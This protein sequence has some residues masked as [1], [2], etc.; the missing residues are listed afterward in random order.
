MNFGKNY[1]YEFRK[2]D[3]YEFCKYDKCEF[4]ITTLNPEG[5]VGDAV[6]TNFHRKSELIKDSEN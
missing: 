5:V 6:A 1:K 4:A 2:Y 3:K